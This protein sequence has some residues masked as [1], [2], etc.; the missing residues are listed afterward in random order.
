MKVVGFL[1]I[2]FLRRRDRTVLA[3]KS[4]FRQHRE[5]ALII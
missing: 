2:M 3:D 1:K 5:L 4:T